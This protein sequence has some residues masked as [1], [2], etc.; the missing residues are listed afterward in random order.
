MPEVHCFTS[1]SFS[2]LSR[3]RLLVRTL[4]KFHPDWVLWACVSDR[5]PKQLDYA[6][7]EEDFDHVIWVDD[8]PVKNVEGWIFQHSVVELCTAVKGLVLNEI[9]GRGAAKVIYLDP[10]IALFGDLS[11]VVGL[12][13][14]HPVVLTPHQV[15]PESEAFAI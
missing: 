13:D 6:P 11:E 8:L 5:P 12:L 7:D 15:D 4:R 3:A 9:L 14:T 1:F 2:Y 10:D